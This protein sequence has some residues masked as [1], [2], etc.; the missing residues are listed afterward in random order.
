MVLSL[1]GKVRAIT[2][3]AHLDIAKVRSLVIGAK[4]EAEIEDEV[5]TL[6][7]ARELL[8]ASEERAREAEARALEAETRAEAMGKRVQE[9]LGSA[10]SK[11]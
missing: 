1:D 7:H 5:L 2:A 11:S 3:M 4:E 8:A 6:E 10:V 9:M